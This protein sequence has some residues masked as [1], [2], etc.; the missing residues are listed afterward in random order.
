VEAHTRR[1]PL[2]ERAPGRNRSGAPRAVRH[3]RL[4]ALPAAAAVQAE[5]IED[6]RARNVAVEQRDRTYRRMLM[7]ADLISASMSLL[8][9]ITLLGND[10]L[11]LASFLGLPLIVA[12]GKIKGLYDRDELLI[13]KTT[14]E[15][16][17]QLFQLATLY[18]LLFWLGEDLLVAGAMGHGQVVVLWASLL[19]LSVVGRRLARMLAKRAVSTERILFIGDASSYDRLRSKFEDDRVDAELV[20]RMSLQRTGRSG[21]RGASKEELH[22]LLEWTGAHRIVIEPQTLPAQEMLDFVRAAKNVGVRVSLLPRVLDVVGSSVVFDDLG[23]MTL[24]GVRRFGLSRS[25]RLVK[26]SLDLAGGTLALIAIAPVMTI[27]A[28]AIRLDSRGPVLFRQTRVGRDGKHFRICKFR[29]MCTDAEQRKAELRKANQA[30]G[31]D[32]GLFKIEDDPRI[33][34]VGRLLRKTSL[35]ELPQLFNVFAGDMSLVGPRPLVVDEDEQITGYDR[36]R[37]QLTPGMTGPWQIMGSARVPL[38]EMVKIDYLYVAGWSLWEDLKIMLR[39]V[40]YML[41]R[42]GM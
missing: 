16:V 9:I 11:R 13:R 34:R 40:P 29:T 7:Y 19:V 5:A 27:I 2:P 23:G 32:N 6:G 21:E 14:M 42:R 26:R 3:A 24:L 36:R 31:V 25:S 41:A 28:L 20:G 8:L 35:D 1:L 18:T 17:P 15:E 39:T 37:L 12:V 30:G 33:T 4:T 22:E 38:P 10:R